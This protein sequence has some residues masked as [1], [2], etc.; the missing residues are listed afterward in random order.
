MSDI[1]GFGLKVVIIAQ[2]ASGDGTGTFPVGFTVTQ[3]ADDADPFDIGSIDIADKAMG[4]NGDLITW[5]KAQALPLAIAVIPASDDD[6]NLQILA[7]ANR[8]GKGKSAVQD[9][10]T[11]TGIYPDGTTVT[12]TKGRLLGAMFGKSVSSAGRLKSK[13]YTFAFEGK[14]GTSS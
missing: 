1:S 11:I 13:V 3:F 4:L 14:V 12:Y 9:I 7:D 2:N 10:I 5:A 8:V 6:V